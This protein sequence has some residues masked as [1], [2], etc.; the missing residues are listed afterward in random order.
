MGFFSLLLFQVGTN[1]DIRCIYG[2]PFEPENQIQQRLQD[3]LGY[4]SFRKSRKITLFVLNNYHKYRGRLMHQQ[5]C[6]PN[7]WKMAI[8]DRDSSK[9]VICAIL[10]KRFMA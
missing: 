9:K 3:T 5:V 10:R 8:S 2:A 7:D 6:R 1:G 4:S